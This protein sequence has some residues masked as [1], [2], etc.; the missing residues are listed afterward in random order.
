MGEFKK[1]FWQRVSGDS[2]NLKLLNPE[3]FDKETY[4]VLLNNFKNDAWEGTKH[5]IKKELNEN[6]K[7]LERN[8]TSFEFTCRGNRQGYDGLARWAAGEYKGFDV[9]RDSCFKLWEFLFDENPPSKFVFFNNNRIEI[10]SDRWKEFYQKIHPTGSNHPN[11]VEKK[12]EIEEVIKMPISYSLNTILS[13]P[14]GT[15]K[16]F[17]TKEISVKII[18]ENIENAEE[19]LL[20][21]RINDY[22]EGRL[23]KGQI[24]F[25][26]FHSSYSYEEFIEG[27]RPVI[28][29]DAEGGPKF[30]YHTGIFKLFAL[31]ALNSLIIYFLE[32]EPADESEKRINE[33]ESWHEFD[34]ETQRWLSR[35]L[36]KF[37]KD[38]Q[39]LPGRLNYVLI[40]DEINRGD[41]SKIFGELIT[42]IE[43]D[44]RIG[45]EYEIVVKLP[46]TKDSFGVPP[47]LYLL[48]TMN[49]A[50]RSLALIDI[51][52]RRRFDFEEMEP[53]LEKLQD[54]PEA[55]GSDK[56]KEEPFFV[57]SI[58]AVIKLNMILG[59]D[60]DIGKDKKIGHAFFC[61]LEAK[62][63][64]YQAW[65]NKIMPLLEEY[66]YFDKGKLKEVSGQHYTLADG[67]KKGD[68]DIRRLVELL[69][70][71]NRND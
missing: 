42:L 69:K 18:Q 61:N 32:K 58:R 71:E 22:F 47:N 15:G 17:K 55:Y 44:K 5:S 14:P 59:R 50:D 23:S 57:D 13:G 52:L 45:A 7:K 46:Y 2:K 16:T 67:W 30:E 1:L 36:K 66:Y 49:T 25:I 54:N 39:T 31:K 3:D 9:F 4:L 60:P 63:D 21:E 24:E 10:D 8:P 41:I 11:N 34:V 26:T 48:G 38:G 62:E 35:K 12:P 51:A 37:R 29:E 43:K 20:Q 19:Y 6:L 53:K 65:K 33:L 68:E 64:I 70:A 28:K 40:I 27:I 56:V